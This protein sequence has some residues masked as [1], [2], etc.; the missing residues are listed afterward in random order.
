MKTTCCDNGSLAK[1]SFGASLVIGSGCLTLL[2]APLAARAQSYS[3]DWYKVAGGGGTSTGGVY[4]VSATI[5]Q[6]DAG[7]VMSGGNYSITGGFWSLLAVQTPGAPALTIRLTATNTA[8]VSWAFPPT[9]FTLEQ[10]A[11]VSAVSWVTPAEVVQHNG[12]VN[13]IVVNAPAGNRFFRLKK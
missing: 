6:P 9:G 10:A 11:S 8:I 7:P 12:A 13:F 5:G 1:R 4:S 2:F 3:I